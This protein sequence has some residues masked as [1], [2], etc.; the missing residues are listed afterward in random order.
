MIILACLESGSRSIDSI[1]SGF[2]PLQDPKH[3]LKQ[4][5]NKDLLM[6]VV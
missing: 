5:K 1:L 3:C 6:R 2:N 4:K